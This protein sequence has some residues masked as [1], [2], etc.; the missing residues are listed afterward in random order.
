MPDRHI[1]KFMDDRCRDGAGGGIAGAILTKVGP[2][3]AGSSDLSQC[4]RAVFA[5]VIERSHVA[6]GDHAHH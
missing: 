5:D 4:R 3:A 6:R 1:A 2:S